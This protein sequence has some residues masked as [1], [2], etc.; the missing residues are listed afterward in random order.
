MFE[1]IYRGVLINKI[2][3]MN[4]LTEFVSETNY[5]HV[6]G[7]DDSLVAIRFPRQINVCV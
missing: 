3:V 1:L 5:L 7:C 2:N 6:H 4:E